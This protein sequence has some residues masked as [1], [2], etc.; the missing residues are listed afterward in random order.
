MNG[1]ECDARV[2]LQQ[3]VKLPRI[4]RIDFPVVL[5][6]QRRGNVTPV[7]CDAQQ[8]LARAGFE[9]EGR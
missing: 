3:L 4:D 1:V 6:I 9:K 5:P 7:P 8:L 2:L